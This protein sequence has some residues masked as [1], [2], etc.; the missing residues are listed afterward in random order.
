M[1]HVIYYTWVTNQDI[2]KSLDNDKKELFVTYNFKIFQILQSLSWAFIKQHVFF[3]R[4]IVYK[5]SR[6]LKTYPVE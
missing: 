5:R 3:L 2:E 4:K 6:W 1:S